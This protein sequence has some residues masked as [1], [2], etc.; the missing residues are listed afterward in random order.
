V[1][2]GGGAIPSEVNRTREA[3]GGPEV[4]GKMARL[5]GLATATA[6]MGRRVGGGLGI[7][8]LTSQ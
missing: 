2:L 1:K 6:G 8:V 7:V 4:P 3:P 5:P